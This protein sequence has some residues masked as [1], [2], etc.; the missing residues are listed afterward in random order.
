MASVTTAIE[1]AAPG[2]P[3]YPPSWVDRLTDWIERRPGPSWLVYVAAWLALF[4]L[5]TVVKWSDGTYPVGT[6]FP[7]HAVWTGSG[8]YALALMNR[9]DHAAAAALDTFRPVLVN[10]NAY[11]RLHYQLTTL[12]ARPTLLMSLGGLSV[13]VAITVL[14]SFNW[15][16]LKV[17]TSLPSVLLDGLLMLG[18]WWVF[19]A[20]FYHIVH[21]LQLFIHIY[22]KETRINLFE[23]GP[24]YAFSGVTARTAIGII[25]LDYAWYATGTQAMNNL[26]TIGVTLLFVLL[27][28]ITFAWPLWGVHQV[29]VKEKTRVQGE[30]SRR[31]ETACADLH[32]RI[33]SGNLGEMDALNKAMASLVI[34]QNILNGI[35]TWPWQ[36]ETVR[37][38]A[39]AVVLPVILWF[40]LRLLEQALNF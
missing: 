25:L 30:M 28:V 35:S 12:P 8:I 6:F 13:G 22:A 39:T 40:I 1:R 34:E 9:L 3:P 37:A 23:L 27:G 17:G 18:L 4:A 21:Q 15:G 29:L 24:L 33:D 11:S 38:L 32:R 19:G 5:E 14:T 20:L 31:M 26:V 36:S 10:D 2:A 16:L 7:F